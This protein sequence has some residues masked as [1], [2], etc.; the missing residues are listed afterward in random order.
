MKPSRFTEE[1][2]IGIPRE[3][4]AGATTA[5][6]CRKHKISSATFYKWKAKYGGLKVSDAKRLKRLEDENAKL[7]KLLAEAMLD[8]T[9]LKDI[10]AKMVTPA[11]RR[12]AVAHLQAKFEVS[13]RRAC[14]ALGVDRT[15][16]RY[17]SRRPDDP[18]CWAR[19]REL[20]TIRR[21]FGC[22]RLH[23]LMCREGLVMNH[24]K[25]RRLY[26]EER[27]Q[28]RRRSGR[29]RALGN[30]DGN[31]D[32]AGTEPALEPGLH[33]GRLCRWSSVSHAGHRRGLQPRCASATTA[34]ISPALAQA[35]AALTA[36]KEDYNNVCPHSALGNLSPAEHADRSAP[37]TQWGGA[38]RYTE[39]L[40]APPHCSTEPNG[41]KCHRDSPHRWMKL[42]A[43]VSRSFSRTAVRQP[44]HRVA[45]ARLPWGMRL[46]HLSAQRCVHVVGERELFNTNR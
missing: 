35:R 33:V 43:Q 21:R 5:D 22:R 8:N 37:G 41:L 27:L 42:G 36:W 17:R 29:K 34:P 30:P 6:V 26:R 2:I 4:E 38:L 14:T 9:L 46:Q 15:S 45:F 28:V 40:R 13:E 3:Q 25:F 32:P 10:T 1:Q 31:G 16:V 20:A 24:K 39:G 7:K 12:E 19:L 44:A 11:A 18:V 23:V